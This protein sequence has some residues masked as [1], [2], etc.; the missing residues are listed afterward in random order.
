MSTLKKRC[1]KYFGTHDLYKILN[2]NQFSSTDESKLPNASFEVFFLIKALFSVKQAYHREA[3]RCHPD[4]NSTNDATE[5]FQTL[6]E[7]YRILMDDRSKL[8]YDTQ[9]IAENIQEEPSIM[10]T[11][12]QPMRNKYVGSSTEMSAIREAY[13][14]CAGNFERMMSRVPFLTSA[15]KERVRI[16]ILREFRIYFEFRPHLCNY[17]MLI[18][19]FQSGLQRIPR[20]QT[21]W[22]K[23]M[24][25]G[26]KQRKREQ[27]NEI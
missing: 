7:L 20:C 26:T 12:V 24:R 4:R 18:W 25:K 27:I 17:N 3:L 14:K 5:M 10:P 2:L 9:G 21:I 15:D 16:I 11:D 22:M 6:A 23:W 1:E 13:M 19:I 8:K